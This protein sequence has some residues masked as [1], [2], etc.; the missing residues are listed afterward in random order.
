MVWFGQRIEFL[1]ADY[2]TEYL[3]KQYL[4]T[5]EEEPIYLEMWDQALAGI[6]KHLVTYSK[7]THLTIIGERPD[8]L[9]G[10]LSPKM[11]HLVCFMPGTIALSITGGLTIEE[12]KKSGKW[13]QKQEEEMRFA[14]ELLKTCWGMYQAMATG[15]A[16]E[17]SFFEVDDPPHMDVDGPLSS[18]DMGS[19]LDAPWRSDYT[20]KRQDMHNLQRPE[21]VESLFYLWRI[22]GDVKYREWGWEIF[23]SFVR[24]TVAEDG[25]GFSSLSNANQIP[26]TFR[27][28]MESFWL[29]E[30]LKYFYLLFSP[31]D[32]LPLKDIV[33]NTEAHI[34]PRF[35][36][37]RG[38]K[39]GW[40]R[41]P[42]DKHGRIIED[43]KTGPG[44]VEEATRREQ[45]GE[46]EGKQ[47]VKD[48]V[49]PAGGH[50]VE[51]QTVELIVER[52]VATATA[53]T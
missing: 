10:E 52:I 38:L 21:T 36:L 53:T 35:K 27:D 19:E 18:L 30:T 46:K 22:T 42:R 47:E 26:P 29:A 11:D 45:K 20:I 50:R 16:P 48:S 37:T 41:K 34:F 32:F 31:V 5:S 8:G 15:L 14:A 4:Q 3:I 43:E 1:V 33:I 44:N 6:H 25:A 24:Y 39:T 17:I 13:G 7:H 51:T 28:N 2:V 23:K 12:L 49:P 9:T 40:K